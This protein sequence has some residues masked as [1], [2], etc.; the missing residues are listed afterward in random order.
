MRSEVNIDHLDIDNGLMPVFVW[1]GKV[2]LRNSTLHTAYTGDCINVKHG[3]GLVENCTF[4]GNTAVDTDAIDFDD[5]VNGVIRNN[6]IHAFRGPNSDG[7]DVGEGCVNLLISGNR[8]YNNSDKGISVGQASTTRIE[9]NL[10]VG[11][12]LGI[13]IKDQDSFATVD[14]NTFVGNDVAIAVYEKNLGDGGG[15]AVATNNIFSRSKDAPVTVD[16]LSSLSAS[17]SMSDTVPVAGLNNLLQDPVFTDPGRYDFSLVTTSPAIDAGDPAHAADSDGSRADI[18]ASYVYNPDDYPYVVPNVIVINEILSHSAE[19]A[20]DWIELHNTSSEPFDISGWFLS[21]SKSDLR[22][23]QIAEGTTIPANGFAVFYEDT[24]FGD[25]SSDPG[26]TTAFALNEIGET[27]YLYGPSTDLLLEYLEEETFGPSPTGVSRG[28]YLKSTNTYNFVFTAEPSPGE[29]NSA[30]LVGPIVISEIMYRPDVDGDAE[31]L[32]L[33]NTSDSAV[34]FYDELKDAGWSITAGVTY[35]FPTTN[36]ITLSP[37]ERLL[38]VRDIAAFSAQFNVPEGTQILQ[39]TEGGLNNS[40]EG[41]E[42]SRP[43]DVDELGQRQWV[44]IDRVNYGDDTLWPVEAD[45]EG[46]SLTRADER[47]YGNDVANWLAATPTPGTGAT[48][49]GTEFDTW[50]TTQGLPANANQFGDDADLDGMTNGLEFAI[51]TDPIRIDRPLSPTIIV[52]GSN[53]AITYQI[54]QLRSDIAYSLQQSVD[55]VS[56]WQNVTT[57]MISQQDRASIDAM[58]QNADAK[59]VFFRLRVRQK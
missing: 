19:G 39:W 21:D 7:I 1:Y 41:L 44:R 29:I 28:R 37:G 27:V 45:G 32:E 59:Q 47:A 42:L 46:M 10:I 35:E 33:L 13:G 20:P 6:R 12:V 54:P 15:G 16:S 4:I 57:G 36:P 24:S 25:T 11:C 18:G 34:V 55:L 40:G 52:D 58:V 3:Q 30:P 49:T 22:K 26:K 31:Y 14:Q 56:G 9:K 43:G 2:V 17:Y 23:Y 8:V 50:A 5:V 51:G 38:L 53:I 48:L